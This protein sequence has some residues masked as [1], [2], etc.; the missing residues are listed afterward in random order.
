M[1]QWLRGGGL[2]LANERKTRAGDSKKNSGCVGG[3]WTLA[4]LSLGRLA[5]V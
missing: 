2:E 4:E 1:R 5:S 3:D